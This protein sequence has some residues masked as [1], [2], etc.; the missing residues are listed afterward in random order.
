[1]VREAATWQKLRCGA[2]DG[3]AAAAA[4]TLDA[5]APLD[6]ARTGPPATR[7]LATE[8][9]AAAA[10]AAQR[11]AAELAKRVRCADAATALRA[12]FFVQR[13]GW[14]AAVAR[15]G[16]RVVEQAL[17]ALERVG[18]ES[19]QLPQCTTEALSLH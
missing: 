17:A 4:A 10:L 2:I 19:E 8:R 1:M 16:L 15:R 6:A 3:S 11:R 12:A 18:G 14:K 5:V 13:D 7:G 9:G